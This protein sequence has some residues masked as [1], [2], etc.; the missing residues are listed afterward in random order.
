MLRVYFWAVFCVPLIYTFILV[1]ILH[2]IHYCSFRVSFEI[3][4]WKSRR[5][6]WQPIP[7]SLPG[8]SQGQRSLVGCCLWGCTELDMTEVTQQQQQQ[9]KSASFTF[10]KT[11]LGILVPLHF[12]IKFR[13]KL[14][15][16]KKRKDCWG[17]DRD[18]IE[19]VDQFEEN[20]HLNKCSIYDNGIFIYLDL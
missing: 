6:K 18:Y 10:F 17:F 15:N 8:E 20:C 11:A 7:V 14:V 5:R 16:S 4:Q 2:Y 19:S 9:W 12:H 3:R 13:I 1:P